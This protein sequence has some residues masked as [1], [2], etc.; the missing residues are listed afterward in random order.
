MSTSTIRSSVITLLD[1]V[2]GVSN[3][4]A[5]EP[6]AFDLA[7]ATENRTDGDRIHFWLVKVEDE[8]PEMGIGFVELRRRVLIE[9]F[10]G[11]A[12][13]EPGD[14]TASDVTAKTLLT[15]VVSK[16]ANADNRTLTATVLDSWDYNT[17]PITVV[18]RQVGSERHLC[19]RI[20]FTFLTAEDA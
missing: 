11:I 10:I 8:A 12:R 19:H 15:G 14:G 16:F 20:A 4:Y 18:E 17:E 5:E 2:T 7:E 13:D 3:V 6:V 1:A 9:G